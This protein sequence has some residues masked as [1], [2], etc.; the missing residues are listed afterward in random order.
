MADIFEQYGIKADAPKKV[1]VLCLGLKLMQQN[2]GSWQQALGN[3]DWYKDYNAETK[4]REIW[5]HMNILDQHM[6]EMRYH[7][8]MAWQNKEPA[9]LAEE[10]EQSIFGKQLAPPGTGPRNAILSQQQ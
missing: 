4:S 10:V 5:L 1:K 6:N 7:I 2:Y 8:L 9:G 3:V